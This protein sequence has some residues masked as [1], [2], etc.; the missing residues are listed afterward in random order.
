LDPEKTWRQHLGSDFRAPAGATVFAPVTG[1]IVLF[2][3]AP[4]KA[5]DLAY[6]V[7]R[8]AQTNEEHVIGHISSNLRLGAKVAKGKPI[9][10]V[11]DQG[12]NTHVH[13]GFNLGSVERA[14]RHV[15]RCKRDGRLQNCKWGWGKAPYEATEREVRAQGWRNVL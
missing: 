4:G 14:A 9:G 15:T 13:W 8:D 2:D 7:I 6:L 10:Q 3:A 1:T 5:A 11:R 12:S